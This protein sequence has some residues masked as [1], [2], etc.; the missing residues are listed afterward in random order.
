MKTEALPGHVAMLTANIIWGLMSPISKEAQTYFT[1]HDISRIVLP[2]LR[3]IGAAI[4]F[5]LLSLFVKKEKH[6]VK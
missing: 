4:A 5:W 6:Q 3:M 2:S 1:Q